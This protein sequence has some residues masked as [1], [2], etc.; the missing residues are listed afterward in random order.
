M[1]ILR[2]CGFHKQCVIATY[3]PE[4][5]SIYLLKSEDLLLKSNCVEI[6]FSEILKHTRPGVHQENIILQ[7]FPEN[8]LLCVVDL[9][10]LYI[11]R[12]AGLRDSERRFFITTQVSF[13]GFVRATISRWVKLL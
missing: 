6:T 1:R 8:K 9:L 3:R 11:S 13:Q 12:T 10:R 5:Q 4:E 7:P 2:Y